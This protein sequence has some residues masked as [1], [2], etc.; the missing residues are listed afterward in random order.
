MGNFSAA[1]SDFKA[2]IEMARESQ[3]G[4]ERIT[5]WET[6]VQQI[7][8]KRNPFSEPLLQQLR[9]DWKTGEHF[10]RK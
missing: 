2:A 4:K 1:S 3:Q 5:M 10:H 9:D 8:Q 6:W 7:G